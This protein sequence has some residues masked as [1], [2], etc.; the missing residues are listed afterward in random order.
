MYNRDL[1]PSEVGITKLTS[2]LFPLAAL[3][4]IEY[5]I[6]NI[7]IKKNHGGPT[8]TERHVGDLGNIEAGSDG[9]V[10]TVLSDS[11][12]SLFGENTIIGKA[13]V[14]HS[15][16]DDLGLGGNVGSL[17]TGNAGSRV[18]CCLIK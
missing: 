12:A 8:S 7:F 2:K 14:I 1:R 10:V 5:L 3:H 6:G 11:L 4:L 17:T 16:E 15:G 13:I 9:K 18:G